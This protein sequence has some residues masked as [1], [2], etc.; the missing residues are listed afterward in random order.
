M[1]IPNKACRNMPLVK[2]KE[3]GI[4]SAKFSFTPEHFDIF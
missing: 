2:R 4:S 3:G 1:E